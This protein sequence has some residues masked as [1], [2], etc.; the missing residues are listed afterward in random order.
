MQCRVCHEEI[1][2][3]ARKCIHCGSFQ[4]K[5]R[6][7]FNFSAVILSLLVALISVIT[8][9]IP[10]F[11][12]A[13]AREAQVSYEVLSCTQQ[14]VRLI[15]VNGGNSLAVIKS[16]T[17]EDIALK[18]N[19]AVPV[20]KAEIGYADFSM[21]SAENGLLPANSCGKRIDIEFSAPGAS[22]NISDTSKPTCPC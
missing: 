22:V 3:D 18:F 9:S 4:N 13:M 2:E 20:L 21:S 15:A 19:T 14:T 16:G 5:I 7:S 17:F 1:E 10:V 12:A 6:N 8:A 11:K